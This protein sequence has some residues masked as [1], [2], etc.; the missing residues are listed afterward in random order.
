MLVYY[1]L[2]GVFC[3][4]FAILICTPYYWLSLGLGAGFWCIYWLYKIPTLGIVTI[5]LL[6]P[7]ESLFAD[8]KAFTVVK[9]IGYSLI[10]I[11]FLYLI[12]RRVIYELVF[13]SAWTYIAVLFLVGLIGANTSHYPALSYDFLRKLLTSV[14]LF[15][16]T[17]IFA[18]RMNFL[19]LSGLIVASITIT[20]I[21]TGLST[22]GEQEFNLDNRTAGLLSDPNYYALLIAFAIPFLLNFIIAQSHW[23]IRGA[24]ISLM[25]LML[26][27]LMMTFSR[28]SFLVLGFISILAFLHYRHDIPKIPPHFTGLLAIG[29]LAIASALVV[30]VPD[31]FVE[32]MSSLVSIAKGSSGN[33]DRS[34][35]RRTSYIFVGRQMLEKNPIFGG[36]PAMFPIQY[37][38]SSYSISFSISKDNPELYRRAHNTYL[39][40][41]AELGLVGGSAFLIIVILGIRN[42]FRAR[43]LAGKYSRKKDYDL[44]TAFAI[45]YIVF[46]LFMLFLSATYHKYFWI[47]LGISFVMLY[48]QEKIATIQEGAK[49]TK[50]PAIF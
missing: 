41:F 19:A 1:L 5:M 15:F 13:N 45:S 44:T 22:D 29:T 16:A 33:E 9:L 20:A 38:R 27:T 3:M 12:Q 24:L 48:Q 32:R 26:Y 6:V 17:I 34:L 47:L 35:G 8:A 49:L 36:G 42:F 46:C 4:A 31:S 50:N 10:V 40:V 28:S 14:F 21:V 11:A 43:H 2:L 18:H 39:E 30:V 23:I 37:A 25:I 7:F